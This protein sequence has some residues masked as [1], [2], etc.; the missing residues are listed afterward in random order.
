MRRQGRLPAVLKLHNRDVRMI[1]TNAHAFEQMLRHHHSESFILD[2]ALDQQPSMKALLMEVQRDPITAKPIH[3]DFR[4]ISMTERLRIFVPVVLSGDPYGVTQESG[5]L[6][7]LIREVE[8]ECLPADVVEKI[9]V[10]VTPLKLGESLL[11]GALPLG[12]KLKL[13]TDKAIAV[14]AVLAPRLEVEETTAV[15]EEATAAEPEVITKGKEAK[16]KAEGEAAE[17]AAKPK[18]GKA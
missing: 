14:A 8:I 6:D 7:Q 18:G 10:D 16:E 11:A 1:E 15:A 12:E 17:P 5:M 3:A 2:L 13:I 9:T 4:E